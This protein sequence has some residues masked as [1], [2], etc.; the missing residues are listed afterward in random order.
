MEDGKTYQNEEEIR[1]F[2]EAVG[3][4]LDAFRALDRDRKKDVLKDLNGWKASIGAEIEPP[5]TAAVPTGNL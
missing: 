3:D 1:A 4:F 2:G 5:Q